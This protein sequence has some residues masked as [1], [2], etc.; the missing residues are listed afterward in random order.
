MS[1][2]L[3]ELPELPVS[4][5]LRPPLK[6]QPYVSYK[7]KYKTLFVICICKEFYETPSLRWLQIQI[8]NTFQKVFCN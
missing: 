2:E 5:L 3:P 7:Y 6:A 1:T 8:Q 4:N